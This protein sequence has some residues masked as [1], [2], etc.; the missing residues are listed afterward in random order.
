MRHCV[1]FLV[2]VSENVTDPKGLET[3][4][5]RRLQLIERSTSCTAFGWRELRE[6][7]AATTGRQEEQQQQPHTFEVSI[8]CLRTAT[9]GKRMHRYVMRGP[10]AV[11]CNFGAE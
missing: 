7:P 11:A 4:K 2:S 8:T 5:K 10:G 6:I 9:R 3:R 1:F